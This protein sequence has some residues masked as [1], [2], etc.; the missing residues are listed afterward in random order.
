MLTC[1]TQVSSRFEHGPNTFTKPNKKARDRESKRQRQTDRQKQTERERE[2]FQM[3]GKEAISEYS[4]YP[5][6]Y[7]F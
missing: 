2:K 3:L 4:M 7:I 5:R 6:H 1:T